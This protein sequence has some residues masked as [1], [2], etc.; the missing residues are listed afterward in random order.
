[1]KKTLLFIFFGLLNISGLF[2]QSFELMKKDG[3]SIV[4]D[5]ISILTTDNTS[6]IEVPM[7]VKNISNKSKDVLI[8][9]Y[10]KE[11]VSGSSASFCWG[12]SCFDI[13]TNE[14]DAFTSIAASDTAKEFHSDYTPNQN[15]G[16]TE[17]MFT[18]YNKNN[19]DDSVSVTI[20]YEVTTTTG[21]ENK[22]NEI[23]ESI[24][25]YPNPVE[26]EFYIS[27]DLQNN[28]EGNISV[29][30]IVGKKVKNQNMFL[31]EKQVQ[32]DFSNLKTGIY[33]CTFEVDGI[34]IKSE[35]IIKR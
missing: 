28:G 4:N 7:Y 15:D 27:Y 11:M 31:T 33:I 24:K 34:L 13:A 10:T 32:I 23:K 5:S 35:K 14:P 3:S 8:K 12:A 30:D 26:N 21:I 18:F 29:Y 19:S 6:V 1:M 22:L 2:A 17:I 16:I 20:H 25:T 9:V